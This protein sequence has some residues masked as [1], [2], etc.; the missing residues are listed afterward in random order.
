MRAASHPDPSMEALVPRSS[1]RRNTIGVGLAIILLAVAWWSPR[2]LRPEV[3]RVAN[4]GG[5]WMALASHE[6][7]L[8][9]VPLVAHGWPSVEVEEVR[10]VRGAGVAGAWVVLGPGIVDIGAGD[11]GGFDDGEAYLSSLV[12]EP[13]AALELPRSIDDGAEARLFVIWDIVDCAALAAAHDPETDRLT[14]ALRTPI[15]TEV[16]SM[17]DAIGVPGFD[18]E[19][20]R[21]SG[22]C[23]DG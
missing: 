22:A 12:A 14:V 5:S 8:V 17:L 10:S 15:G 13:L 20:L 23:P 3:E 7:V 4:G 6:Q 16:E 11:P 1:R 2:L 21:R 18:V 9:D 19:T